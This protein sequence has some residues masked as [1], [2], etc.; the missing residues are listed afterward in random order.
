[1][2]RFLT[3]FEAKYV[4]ANQPCYELCLGEM[5]EYVRNRNNNN[6]KSEYDDDVNNS[7]VSEYDDIVINDY[8]SEYDDIVTNEVSEYDDR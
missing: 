8:V 3:R 6:V 4:K 7:G 5:N 1:M 2:N